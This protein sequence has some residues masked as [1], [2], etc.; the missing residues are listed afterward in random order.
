[1]TFNFGLES[2]ISCIVGDFGLAA[3]AH[4][5]I[6]LTILK[7]FLF[8]CIAFVLAKFIFVMPNQ[9][10]FIITTAAALP[11]GSQ[12]YYFSYRYNSLQK[13]ISSNIVLS[14]FVSFFTISF[15]FLLFGY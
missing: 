8:P 3:A 11:S 14:T 6:I 1:M 13:I 15:I 5:S 9:L 12:T 7:N 10:V 4:D 2:S